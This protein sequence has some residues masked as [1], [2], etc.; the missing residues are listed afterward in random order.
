MKLNALLGR[1][2]KFKEVQKLE[3]EWIEI[4]Q[5]ENLSD[6]NKVLFVLRSVGMDPALGQQRLEAVIKED[7]LFLKRFLGA[8]NELLYNQIDLQQWVSQEVFDRL[9]SFAP[10]AGTICDSLAELLNCQG[11]AEGVICTNPIIDKFFNNGRYLSLDLLKKTNLS[12][13]G[14]SHVLFRLRCLNFRMKE[15]TVSQL[16]D[17]SHLSAPIQKELFPFKEEPRFTLADLN[18]IID[19]VKR[20]CCL[21]EELKTSTQFSAM[22]DEP[23]EEGRTLSSQLAHVEMGQIVS[24]AIALAKAHL[25]I[26]EN[27]WAVVGFDSKKFKTAIDAVSEIEPSNLLNF[28]SLK[29]IQAENQHKFDSLIRNLPP[30]KEEAGCVIS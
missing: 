7:P 22:L 15:D 9:A 14:I 10:F 17:L 26:K 4:A 19:K 1:E 6:Q 2:L 12:Q 5:H 16:L 27:L 28:R 8:L 11:I 25:P 23:N 18:Q 21:A 29:S 13:F 3:K 30:A 24:L 20:E